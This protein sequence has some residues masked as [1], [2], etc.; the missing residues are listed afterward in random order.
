LRIPGI[1]IY[2]RFMTLLMSLSFVATASMAQKQYNFFYGKVLETGTKKA[3]SGVNLSIEGSRIGTV[4][5]KKGAFSF[6]IDSIP[7]TL[8]VSYIGFETKTIL[9]DATSF[10]L[11]LYLSRKATELEEVEIKANMWEPFFKDEHY[12]VLDYEI[13]SNMVYLLVYRQYLSNALLIC[14]NLVGDT[15]AKS[16]P[17]YFKPDRLFRDCLG[18]LHV[19]SRDSGFQ[20]FRQENQLQ[21][22]HPV[23]LKKYDNV[24][25]N[26]VAST[27]D[28]L[29]FQNVTDRGLG[30]EYYG[31]NRMTMMKNSLTNIRDEKKLKMLRRN[32][33]EAQLLGNAKQPT[34]RDDFVTW[35]YVHKILYRPVKTSLCKIGSYICIFNIPDRQIEFYDTAGNFSYKLALKIGDV[36]D[37]RWSEDIIPDATDGRVYTVFTRNGTYGV[38]EININDGIL[39]KRISLPHLYPRKIKVYNHW[40]YYLYDVAG[41][42][43][44][45]MLHRQKL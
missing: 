12:S 24:L 34:G 27:Q 19:F 41:D 21:L 11:T 6:F 32:P 18:F 3:I 13:D 33:A 5:D 42:P 14:K 45:R 23:G 39:K 38:F 35:N 29:F 16:D 4:S 40:V 10:S 22:I 28:V 43:D 25:K 44:N 30:V 26:C 9:L 37:G 17:L 8:V 1:N 36:N 2:W 15:V 20:V 7:A 31:I